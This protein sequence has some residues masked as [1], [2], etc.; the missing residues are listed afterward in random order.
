MHFYTSTDS[1]L[2][3]FGNAR[4]ASCDSLMSDNDDVIKEMIVFRP[5]WMLDFGRNKNLRR[6]KTG[7]GN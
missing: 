3:H 4:W 6:R 7:N 5:F 2:V 1:G